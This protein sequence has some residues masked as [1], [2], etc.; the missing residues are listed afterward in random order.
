[1]AKAKV[2]PKVL[3]VRWQGDGDEAWL[4]SSSDI[5]C[6]DIED[7]ET[8][9]VGVYELKRKVTAKRVLQVGPDIK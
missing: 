9:V 3:N 8:V 6:L 1:M 5:D 2:L 7:D 4:Q